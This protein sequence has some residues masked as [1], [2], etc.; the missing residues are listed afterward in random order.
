MDTGLELEHR[1]VSDCQKWISQCYLDVRIICDI[2]IDQILEQFSP[3]FIQK[4]IFLF[5][6][7]L[8]HIYAVSLL[9]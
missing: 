3:Y 8:V 5:N 9:N 7:N 2:K 4:V 6:A 1:M